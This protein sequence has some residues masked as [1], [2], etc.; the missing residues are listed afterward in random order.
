[1]AQVL[2]KERLKSENDLLDPNFRLLKSVF[3]MLNERVA[4][5][6]FKKV[7]N[8]LAAFMTNPHIRPVQVDADI[9]LMFENPGVLLSQGSQTFFTKAI[10]ML[11]SKTQRKSTFVNLDRI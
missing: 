2:V 1:L 7:E 4:R 10:H 3:A 5:T 8:N 9:D 6:Q 11:E